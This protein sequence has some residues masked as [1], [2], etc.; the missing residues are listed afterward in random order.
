[1][2]SSMFRS[3]ILLALT[4]VVTGCAAIP[5]V[6]PPV[7]W[8][9][10]VGDTRDTSIVAPLGI[11]D[12]M[13]FVAAQVPRP[14]RYPWN[15]YQFMQAFDKNTGGF[16]WHYQLGRHPDIGGCGITQP[17]FNDGVVYIALE[18]SNIE[19]MDTTT[20]QKLWV[21]PPLGKIEQGKP[22]FAYPRIENCSPPVV[23]DA[24]VYFLC[25]YLDMSAQFSGDPAGD[26]DMLLALDRTSGVP[27]WRYVMPRS[28]SKSAVTITKDK[29]I[30]WD[31]KQ[32]LHAVSRE[33][34]EDV[35]EFRT[36]DGLTSPPFEINGRIF[37]ADYQEGHPSIIV[38]EEST[39]NLLHRVPVM[40]EKG[41]IAHL[42]IEEDTIFAVVN[43]WRVEMSSQGH[44]Y[45]ID[46]QSGKE[47]WRFDVNDSIGPL[48]VDGNAIYFS[49][50]SEIFSLTQSTGAV[51]LRF[52]DA[53]GILSPT[54]ADSVIY[55]GNTHGK[56]YA[57]PVK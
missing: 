43:E 25:S 8:K 28:D 18:C 54:L 10:H 46:L 29:V 52:H 3:L 1:M 15:S 45:A 51:K 34:G 12:N 44:L 42:H 6:N 21:F 33:T 27:L 57:I 31:G 2:K 38:L 14:G 50:Y 4:L 35:W 20:G 9:S 22:I 26:A 30:F 11:G 19:A 47:N 32:I 37:T 41:V 7:K 23:K 17:I 49:T 13:V 55:T 36:E 39:G 16:L 53:N 56:I 48:V 5:Y 40:A 24:T